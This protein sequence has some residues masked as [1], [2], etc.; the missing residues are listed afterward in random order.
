MGDDPTKPADN[1]KPAAAGDGK[2]PA[3]GAEFK[4]S[5]SAEKEIW[6]KEAPKKQ[7]GVGDRKPKDPAEA[8]KADD[9]KSALPSTEVGF[10]SLYNKQVEGAAFKAG[11]DKT[12]VSALSGKASGEALGASVNLS[13]MKAK[14][15]VVKAKAEG[16]VGH[17]QVDLV[18]LVK[19]LFGF[20]DDPKPPPI[21]P[22]SPMAARLMDKT[23]HGTPLAPGPGSVNVFIG[24]M[25]AWRGVI[26]MCACAA[27]GA[28][29]HGAGPSAKGEPSVLINNMPAIR[30]GDWVN[31][32]TG[33]P[34]VIVEGC[35]SV[36]IGTP[37][38]NAPGAK[39]PKEA[40]DDLPWILFESVAEADAG[41]A[42][43]ELKIGAEA[44]L[45]NKKGSAEVVAGGSAAL[46][47]GTIPLK[48][49]LLI[50]FTSYYL[51]LGVS[52]TGTLGSV[53][54]EAG[55]SVKVNDGKKL[56]ETSAGAGAHLGGGL[57]AKFS[58]DVSGK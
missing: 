43:A 49:R 25:P 20:E 28:A 23:T 47:K 27:P 4:P 46:L 42:E 21:G 31:E 18:G 29:P 58:L 6:K 19:K 48:V 35:P 38:P 34:N 22:F 37:A 5:A 2:P 36:F 57:S 12:F 16:T 8:P 40:A 17:A 32:P 55:A 45:K 44:D 52:A 30:M 14:A 3:S 56:F 7:V 50:P 24:G 51:G 15:T 54:A 33:G 9:K 1:G 41:A 13:E 10:K 39:D 53:G 26:D 11:D